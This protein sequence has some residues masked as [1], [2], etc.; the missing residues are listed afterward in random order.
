[1]VIGGGIWNICQWCSGKNGYK[2]TIPWRH[3]VPWGGCT[4]DVQ[5]TSLGRPGIFLS[6]RGDSTR[7]RRWKFR[8]ASPDS[9]T[10]ILSWRMK[11]TY[12]LDKTGMWRALQQ[13][14]GPSVKWWRLMTPVHTSYAA[15]VWRQHFDMTRL[16]E[17]DEVIYVSSPRCWQLD[18]DDIFYVVTYWRNLL[19]WLYGLNLFLHQP[20]KLNYACGCNI[21]NAVC[22]GCTRSDRQMR[23]CSEHLQN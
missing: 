3:A 8:H 7:S 14:S 1:M 20:S 15:G 19:Q 6:W 11:Y 9:W 18:S 13:N 21:R 10:A 2:W 4:P 22:G 5:H 12:V 16:T 17:T 23:F